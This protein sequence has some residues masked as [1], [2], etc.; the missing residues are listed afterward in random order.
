MHSHQQYT[1]VPI[2]PH[3]HQHLLFVDLLMIA[4][5]TSVRWYLIVVLFC[6]SLMASDVE[7]FFICLWAICMFIQ[8]LC[9]FFKKHFVYLFLERWGGREKERERNINV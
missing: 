6:I 8:V 1:R 4:I 9:P 7:H 5:H 2:S 3:P